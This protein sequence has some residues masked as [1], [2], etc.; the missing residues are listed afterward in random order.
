LIWALA[1]SRIS[2]AN[3]NVVIMLVLNHRSDDDISVNFC[4]VMCISVRLVESLFALL[5]ILTKAT[6]TLSV[7]MVVL[8]VL[9][10]L[11]NVTLFG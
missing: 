9:R 3:L 1:T 10:H 2:Y 11:S 6:Y 7:V 4:H 8:H 5:S